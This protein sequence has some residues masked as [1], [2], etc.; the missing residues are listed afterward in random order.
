MNPS[1]R[2]TDD[3]PVVIY[4][5]ASEVEATIVANALADV[6]IESAINGTFSSEF[7]AEAPGEVRVLIHPGDVAAA[8]EVLEDIKTD[9]EINW[10]EVDT[11]D[12]DAGDTQI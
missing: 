1:M 12:T 9:E 3:E 8:K 11:G 10:D 2:P 6:G 5:A 7:R 4:S